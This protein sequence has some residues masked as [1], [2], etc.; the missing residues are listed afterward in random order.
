VPANFV[1]VGLI[2]LALPNAHIIHLRRNPIDTCLSCFSTLFRSTMNFNYDLGELGRFYRAYE[3]LMAHWRAV[4]PEDAKLEVQYEDVVGGIE[5]Q[6]RRILAHCGLAWDEACL[7][8]DKSNRPVNT[9]SAAQVRQPIYGSSVGRWRPY[10]SQLQPLLE[11]LGHP[12]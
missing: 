10:R 7:A 12:V 4:L 1:Y 11:A 8:F 9:A 3:R 2:R 5:T 6:A